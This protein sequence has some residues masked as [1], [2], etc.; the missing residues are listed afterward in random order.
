MTTHRKVV[1]IDHAPGGVVVVLCDDG[2]V[3]R[4][5]G[6][7]AWREMELPP[8]CVARNPTHEAVTTLRAST[9][10]SIRTCR[11]A[12]KKANGD[13]DAAAAAI[14]RMGQA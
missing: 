11:D 6:S 7:S 10:A 4:R 14:R 2:S 1:Q 12:L 8:G 13:A 9:E 5:C 3:W